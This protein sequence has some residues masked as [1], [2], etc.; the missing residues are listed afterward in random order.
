ME[1][2]DKPLHLLP[3]TEFD[4][5]NI[6]LWS[7]RLQFIN[8]LETADP[9]ALTAWVEYDESENPVPKY[10]VWRYR[11]R[12]I[13]AETFNMHYYP[14]VRIF[15]AQYTVST[16]HATPD[17]SERLYLFNFSKCTSDV[18]A[19]AYLRNLDLY[20]YTNAAIN[21]LPAAS[22]F[23]RRDD[24]CSKVAQC[25]IYIIYRSE[26]GRVECLAVCFH[27]DTAATLTRQTTM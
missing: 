8:R 15:K 27:A 6:S 1:F 18:F 23:L 11:G 10:L 17:G 21:K 14:F 3:W 25:M 13:F 7:P 20:M 19:F 9:V 12:G 2:S 16:P 4:F 26:A 24:S 22:H 5:S